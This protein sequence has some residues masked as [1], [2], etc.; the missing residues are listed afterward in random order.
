MPGMPA[1]ADDER[2]SQLPFALLA[3]PLTAF[4]MCVALAFALTGVPLAYVAGV[5]VAPALTAWRAHGTGHSRARTWGLA[6]LSLVTALVLLL[7]AL[8]VLLVL[9]G[10]AM[11]DFD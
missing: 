11:E 4:G 5:L 6:A 9:I 3:A 10:R 1:R 2:A 8:T 7:V